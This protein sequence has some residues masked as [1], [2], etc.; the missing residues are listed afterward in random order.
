MRY[1]FCPKC[2]QKY[3]NEPTQS[4]HPKCQSCGFVFYQNPKPTASVFLENE[5]GEV[6]LVRR[7]V[8]PFKGEWDTP[9]GFCEENEHPE[10]TARREMKEELGVEIEIAG[11]VGIFMDT[12]GDGGD[13]TMNIFYRGKITGGEIRVADDVDAYR[14]FSKNIPRVAFENGR[15]ALDA[16]CQGQSKD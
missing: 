15:N 13:A 3:T 10:K 14:W 7:A 4:I 9:G 6:L 1:S 5:K 16:L 11:M 2:G 8:E 12:Y